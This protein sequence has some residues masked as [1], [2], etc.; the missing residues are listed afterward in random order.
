MSYICM[1]CTTLDVVSWFVYVCLIEPPVP[2]PRF[3]FLLP[4]GFP[5]DP[6][7]G[8]ETVTYVLRGGLVHRD[9]MGVKTPD[10]DEWRSHTGYRVR[11]HGWA[12]LVLFGGR[13]S[14]IHQNSKIPNFQLSVSFWGS[15][16]SDHHPRNTVE[17]GRN[18]PKGRGWSTVYL[19]CSIRSGLFWD[20]DHDWLSMFKQPWHRQ[21]VF[22]ATKMQP[23]RVLSTQYSNVQQLWPQS[24]VRRSL[25]KSYGAPKEP[26]MELCAGASWDTPSYQ[27]RCN[28]HS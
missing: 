3:R 1:S 24:L 19:M 5:A 15:A 18:K 17:G 28:K 27:F 11:A 8:F 25:R 26:Q 14:K 23:Y 9:S 13:Y 20:P 10:I 12:D 16:L 6:H 7:R 4:E 22:I 21:A 2:V